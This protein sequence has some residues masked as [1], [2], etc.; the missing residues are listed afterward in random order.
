MCISL[1]L[2]DGEIVLFFEGWSYK[3][4]LEM[5]MWWGMGGIW[6]YFCYLLYSGVR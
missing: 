1:D 4:I 2:G 6:G 5:G 3:V